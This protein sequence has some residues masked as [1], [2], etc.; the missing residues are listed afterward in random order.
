MHDVQKCTCF[1]DPTW[2]YNLLGETAYKHPCASQ[3]C[4]WLDT[5]STDIKFCEL[6][7]ENHS[8]WGY[9]NSFSW[10]TESTVGINNGDTVKKVKEV[11]LL[12][13]GQKWMGTDGKAGIQDAREDAV[14]PPP[15]AMESSG[16]DPGSAALKLGS[17]GCN[18]ST[19]CASHLH[20]MKSNACTSQGS[21]QDLGVSL[22]NAL[23]ELP[24]Y[25]NYAISEL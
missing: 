18:T 7:W 13:V 14:Y 19:F 10:A 1:V 9:G 4:V 12:Q 17:L 3:G 23:T 8:Q 20:V 21:S 24:S 6:V 22:W 5:S 15:E 11:K 2:T 16:P 25:V